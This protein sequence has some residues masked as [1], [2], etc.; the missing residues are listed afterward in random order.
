[1]RKKLLH[2]KVR[3]ANPDLRYIENIIIPFF[4]GFVEKNLLSVIYDLNGRIIIATNQFA[5]FI[6]YSNWHEI[7]SRTLSDL[8]HIGSNLLKQQNRIRK[9]IIRHE[10][11]VTHLNILPFNGSTITVMVFHIPLFN[12]NGVVIATRAIWHRVNLMDLILNLNA[13][14]TDFDS[15]KNDFDS[16]RINLT[17]RQNEI[18]FLL[19]I[20]FSQNYIASYL[21]ISRGTV[22]KLLNDSICPAF[23]VE[24]IN[25]QLL[26]KR[27]IRSGYLNRVSDLF[28][29]PQIIEMDRGSELSF[30]YNLM[31]QHDY[32]TLLPENPSE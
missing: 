11:A 14:M 10:S 29:K 27:V 7:K 12:R 2:P 28:L 18:V 22:S 32:S 9:S 6:G 16:S 5:Q 25:T 31:L 4:T 8:I 23:G 15:T 1:M 30:P 26:V 17:P 3:P 24:G 19:A 20:G 21:S 13:G